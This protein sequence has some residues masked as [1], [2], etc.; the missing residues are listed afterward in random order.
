MTAMA[1]YETA[2]SLLQQL[3]AIPSFSRQEQGTAAI[4]EQFLTKQGV[5]VFRCGNNIWCANKYFAEKKP[6]VLLNSHHDTIQP[7][8]QYARDPFA[9]ILE[10]GKLYGLGSND[11]GGALV[12]LITTF[13]HFYEAENLP[14]NLL[15]AATAEEEISGAQGIEALLKDE[16][17]HEFLARHDAMIDMAIVGEPT[18]T[19]LAVAEKGLLVLDCTVVGAAGHAAREEG[20]NAIYK[21]ITDIQWLQQYRFPKVS[22]WLGEVKMT[23]T[24]IDSANKAHNIVPAQCHYVVDIRVNDLYT[25]EE[26]LALV[27]AHLQAEVQPRSMRLRSTSIPVTHPLVSAGLALG[28]TCY[29]S[30]TLSDKALIPFPA[31]KCGPGDSARSHSADEF[32]YLQEIQDGIE[33]YI[34][35]L[36]QL[37]IHLP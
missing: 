29:G 21:A 30:P 24:V 37:Q 27:Q 17:L 25:H 23:V 7:N 19:Q 2:L 3:I 28:K 10:D 20:E 31:L 11:A 34:Q 15:L 36:Q 35:L 1:I 12:A 6:V 14:F 9:P 4:I 8:I 5:P 26:I 16:T 13:L 18:G 33:T 32:I 22:E